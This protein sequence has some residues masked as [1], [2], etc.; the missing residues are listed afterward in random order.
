MIPVIVRQKLHATRAMSLD[1]ALDEMEL[2]GH[3]F[4]LFIEEETLQPC[5]VYHRQGWTYGVIRLDATCSINP[6]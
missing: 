1:D 2:V 5:V 4:F 6:S 3:P